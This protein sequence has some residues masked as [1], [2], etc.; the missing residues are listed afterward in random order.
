MKKNRTF[1]SLKP[2][3]SLIPDNIKKIIKNTPT[4]DISNLKRSWEKILGKELSN[5][6]TLLKVQKNN[7][8]NSLFLKVDRS[9]LIDIDYSRDEIAE[10]INSFLGFKYISKILINA[11]DNKSPQETKKSLNLNKKMEN[12]IDSIQDEDLK[13]KLKNFNKKNEK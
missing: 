1:S 11:H 10:K 3:R 2:I 8:E 7:S 9:D 6:C 5:K 4:T 13:K 12:L